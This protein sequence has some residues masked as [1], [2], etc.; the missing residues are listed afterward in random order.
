MAKL[1]L[2]WATGVGLFAFAVYSWHQLDFHPIISI[3][4][5]L[6]GLSAVSQA[7]RIEI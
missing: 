5:G 2:T 4:L 6:A 3:I 7:L 1:I